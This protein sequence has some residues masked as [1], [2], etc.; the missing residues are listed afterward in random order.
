MRLLEEDLEERL[1]THLLMPWLETISEE[2][3]ATI[4]EKAL[5]VHQDYHT[6]CMDIEEI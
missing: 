5:K 4:M 2:E 1:E 6:D 3:F